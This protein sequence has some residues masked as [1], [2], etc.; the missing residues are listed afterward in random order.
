MVKIFN[1]PPGYS[2]ELPHNLVYN[3]DPFP[4]IKPKKVVHDS[5]EC[6]FVEGHIWIELSA[7]KFGL[8][9][10]QELRNSKIC[11]TCGRELTYETAYDD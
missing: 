1:I 7:D 6:S 10:V 3:T 11:P 5:T 8:F 9:N 4:V 2:V